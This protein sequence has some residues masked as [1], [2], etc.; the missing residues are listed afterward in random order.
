MLSR[1]ATVDATAAHQRRLPPPS[2][3]RAAGAQRLPSSDPP[4]YSGESHGDCGRSHLGR[5][6]RIQAPW[7]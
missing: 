7:A 1:W 2:V 5:R 3:C 4:G 6:A